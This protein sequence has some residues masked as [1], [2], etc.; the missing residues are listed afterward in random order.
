MKEETSQQIIQAETIK[1]KFPCYKYAVVFLE[2]EDIIQRKIGYSLLAP[3]FKLL[4]KELQQ[5]V[6]YI[7]EIDSEKRKMPYS[8]VKCCEKIFTE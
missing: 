1:E 4:P 3:L 6:S 5:Y 8:F 7:W 2:S